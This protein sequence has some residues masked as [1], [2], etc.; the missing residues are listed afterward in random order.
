MV[1]TNKPKL[2]LLLRACP[3]E[4]AATS[5]IAFNVAIVINERKVANLVC[6]VS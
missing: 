6:I 1:L 2:A 5:N 3:F 4:E